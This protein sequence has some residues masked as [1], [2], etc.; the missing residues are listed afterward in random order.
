M[1]VILSLIWGIIRQILRTEILRRNSLF[2]ISVQAIHQHLRA[3]H[4]HLLQFSLVL[5]RPNKLS[6]F[7]PFFFIDFSML[8][9]TPTG[10][11]KFLLGILFFCLLT[12]WCIINILGYFVVLHILHNTQWETK[13]PK[14]KPYIN[15]FKATNYFLLVW[16]ITFVIGM[17]VVVIGICIRLLY[18]E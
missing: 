6:Y 5:V 7:I 14:L 10:F 12:L 17:Y 18:F 13:Y 16:E 1:N 8:P 11:H 4:L 3:L 15:Y 2:K 9:D